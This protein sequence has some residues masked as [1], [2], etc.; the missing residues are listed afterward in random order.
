LTLAWLL[1]SAFLLSRCCRRAHGCGFGVAVALV[2]AGLA[3]FVAVELAVAGLALFVAVALA[4]AAWLLGAWLLAEIC[5]AWS[6]VGLLS[7]HL[8]CAWELRYEGIPLGDRPS[9]LI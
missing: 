6:W 2:I 3:L 4:V 9:H 7:L 1:G 5:Y 8:E